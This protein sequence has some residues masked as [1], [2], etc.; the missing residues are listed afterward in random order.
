MRTPSKELIETCKTIRRQQKEDRWQRIV[1]F[2]QR[3][4]SSDTNAHELHS[5]THE[6][7]EKKE[8]FQLASV[9]QINTKSI[10]SVDYTVFRDH[11]Y[12]HGDTFVLTLSNDELYLSRKQHVD[13]MRWLV[14]ATS[15]LQSVTIEQNMEPVMSLLPYNVFI[16]E[17]YLTIHILTRRLEKTTQK[18]VIS[19]IGEY[20]TEA[21]NNEKILKQHV[22]FNPQINKECLW[23]ICC[24]NTII[25]QILE[26][27]VDCKKPNEVFQKV[28]DKKLNENG[29]SKESRADDHELTLLD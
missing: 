21:Q 12:V 8:S 17:D 25:A 11:S 14:S 2:R 22:I 28:D 24:D 13:N 16:S 26:L 29:Q 9:L 5:M 18:F 6:Y 27:S 7:E 19:A 15:S 3:L 20:L 4:Q 1:K 10:D 23:H